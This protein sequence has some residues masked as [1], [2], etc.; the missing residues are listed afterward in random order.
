[1]PTDSRQQLH[2]IWAY[3]RWLALFVVLTTVV[4]YLVSKSQ[5]PTYKATALAQ[6]VSAAEASGQVLA[7]EEQQTITN[8]YLRI[9]QTSG[10]YTLGAHNLGG[11]VTPSE[12]ASHV[13]VNPETDTAVFDVSGSG[14]TAATAVA[15]ANAY[16]NAFATYVE[17]LQAAQRKATVDRLQQ[18]INTAETGIATATGAGQAALL[19]E[20]LHVLQVKIGEAVATPS[21]AIRVLG[22]APPPTS[23]ASPQ[24]KRNAILALI[25]ALLLGS[26]AI[27]AY[28]IL[29]DRYRDAD[30]AA[31]DLKLPLLG[32]IPR[33]ALHEQ[34]AIE[35]FRR[36][37]TAAI[38]ELTGRLEREPRTG[39]SNGKPSSAQSSATVLVTAAERGAGKSYTTVGLARALAAEGWHTI[40][41]DGDLRKPTLHDQLSVRPAP[42]LADILHGDAADAKG[43]LQGVSIA[44]G[45]QGGELDV[46]AAGP[47]TAEATELLSSRRMRDTM[48]MLS[49]DYGYVVLD[50][51]PVLPVVDAIVLARYSQGVVFVVD[52]HRSR[53]RDVRRAMQ[54]LRAS[55]A[56]VL[57]FVFNRAEVST[58]A[59]GY[60]ASMS[61]ERPRRSK[62]PVR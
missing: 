7:P 54:T 5:A 28:S 12:F 18:Q 39:A 52:A 43:V 24:P 26:G 22:S 57:G 62:E 41:V 47:P 11:H 6:L 4:T 17:Q 25:A 61:S 16:A 10:V 31:A 13:S 19:R 1:M 27:L 40:A 45:S 33:A 59:Y 42:G 60:G 30:E 38:F 50:S 44:P 32:E 48:E 23:P 51:S 55:Q 36:L 35:A 37:R 53:R 15:Y 56:P 29:T 8:S 34:P 20:Q 49:D 46:I 58:L 9:A 2:T 3:R 21:D 14:G